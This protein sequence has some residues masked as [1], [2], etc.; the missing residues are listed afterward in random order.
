VE[1]WCRANL[2]PVLGRLWFEVNALQALASAVLGVPSVGDQFEELR[3]ALATVP[4]GV[5]RRLQRA[6]RLRQ[7]ELVMRE[8]SQ[9]NLETLLLLKQGTDRVL[10]RRTE[11]R[12][13]VHLLARRF[14]ASAALGR[15]AFAN[16]VELVLEAHRDDLCEAIRWTPR[17]AL[18]A[19]VAERYLN[20]M[21][22]AIREIEIAAS[23][24][25]RELAGTALPVSAPLILGDQLALQ[26]RLQIEHLPPDGYDQMKRW[27]SER[28]TG[29]SEA[30][31]LPQPVRLVG[32]AMGRAIDGWMG[33]RLPDP[34]PDYLT[35]VRRQ[36]ETH[37]SQIAQMAQHQYTT[38]VDEMRRSLAERLARLDALPA[39]PAAVQRELRLREQLLAVTERCQL[40]LRTA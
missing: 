36:W 20:E 39:M 40:M 8:I 3:S 29:A 19:T 6:S 26:M 17:A 7:I 2:Q 31:A 5:R 10:T 33:N 12:R 22:D 16:H 13:T 32:A 9:H 35:A 37:S 15:E 28:I 1:Q 23:T 14:E 24:S 34:L 30:V 25:L 21:S 11:E 18:S 27:I 4:L 38:R